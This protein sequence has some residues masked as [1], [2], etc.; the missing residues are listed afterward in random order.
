VIT[1]DSVYEQVEP[2][3]SRTDLKVSRVR[4]GQQALTLA[5]GFTYDLI[6]SQHPLAALDFRELF[7]GLRA[8]ECESRRSPMLI[9]TRDTRLDQVAKFLDGVGVQACCIDA[10]P[11]QLERALNELVGLAVRV[12]ARVMVEMQVD[13]EETSAYGVFRAVNISESG[14]LLRS[15]QPPPLGRKIPLILRLPDEP[16]PISAIGEV[17]RHTRPEVEGVRGAGFRLHSIEA[18]GRERLA[19]LVAHELSGS[20]H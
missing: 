19:A 13:S 14:L 18:G 11:E 2:L 15:S 6:F 1:S 7:A 20:G 9:L 4:S 5:R 10:A 16:Q 12:K 17:V 8:E 3:L